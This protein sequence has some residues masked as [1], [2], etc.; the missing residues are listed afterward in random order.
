MIISYTSTG[1]VRNHTCIGILEGYHY[2]LPLP[3]T[4]QSKRCVFIQAN[5][6]SSHSSLREGTYSYPQLHFKWDKLHSGCG[7][8]HKSSCFICCIE[9]KKRDSL[10]TSNELLSLNMRVINTLHHCVCLLLTS[11][12]WKNWTHQGSSHRSISQI[13][14]EIEHL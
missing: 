9:G 5:L 4:I 14:I 6:K 3:Y 7:Y 10:N 2:H 13:H 8:P 1:Y 12:G 11:S